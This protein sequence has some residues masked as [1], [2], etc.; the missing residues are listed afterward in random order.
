L[1]KMLYK[2]SFESLILNS[3]F[4]EINFLLNLRKLLKVSYLVENL[5]GLT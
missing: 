3:M 2:L 4:F 5:S 1:V